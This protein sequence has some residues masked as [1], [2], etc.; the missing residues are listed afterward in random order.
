MAA[1]LEVRKATG[2]IFYQLN[3]QEDVG[4]MER[5]KAI[6][7]GCRAYAQA[8]AAMWPS[9]LEMVGRLE[10][11]VGPVPANSTIFKVIA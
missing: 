9:I 1:F 5:W 7:C 2:T 6:D 10:T 4:L 8:R 11:A 3:S